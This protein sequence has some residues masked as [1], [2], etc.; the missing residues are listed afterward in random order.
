MRGAAAAAVC[1]AVSLP[2]GAVAGDDACEWEVQQGEDAG[3]QHPPAA[4]PPWEW[5]SARRRAARGRAPAWDEVFREHG[6]VVRRAANV[7]SEEEVDAIA[8]S[9]PDA[10]WRTEADSVDGR[11][12][13]EFYALHE[14]RPMGAAFPRAAR[15]WLW[16]EVTHRLLPSVRALPGGEAAVPCT[17]LIRRYAPGE[18]SGIPLHRDL[19]TFT[20]ITVSLTGG[21]GYE[22]GPFVHT[23]GRGAEG[24]RFFL[25]SAAGDALFYGPNTRHGVAVRGRGTRISLN[26]WFQRVQAECG[27]ETGSPGAAARS[28]AQV[29]AD[30]DG[31]A[32]VGELLVHVLDTN[33]DGALDPWD[34]EHMALLKD[35]AGIAPRD[36]REPRPLREVDVS[37]KSTDPSVRAYL[38]T[39]I[40]AYLSLAAAFGDCGGRYDKVPAKR[41]TRCAT[42][43]PAGQ[44]R[45]TT[46]HKDWFEA[47]HLFPLTR[48]LE[49]GGFDWNGDLSLDREE[50]VAA[51]VAGT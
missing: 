3:V 45:R 22:G 31:A 6:A 46:L 34:I 38:R 47:L 17:L 1:A 20:T 11:P 8:S 42:H 51:I 29:D 26:I 41:L 27:H 35:N 48:V 30:G 36:P 40:P 10:A 44:A 12:A 43:S 32:S 37:T 21:R 28:F 24:G 2:R 19:G 16:A 23:R 33:H 13:Y 4:P 18:R 5:P 49:P 14:G 50:Y 15:Q 39:N 9:V 7:F 25:P